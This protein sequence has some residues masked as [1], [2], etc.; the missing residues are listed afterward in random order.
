MNPGEI[1]HWHSDI[2]L[3]QE[4]RNLSAT[5]HNAFGRQVRSSSSQISCRQAVR[6]VP[7]RN[8]DFSGL[9]AAFAA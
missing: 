9:S 3:T 4:Q 2:L 8:A 6:L 1:K 5:E 7:A